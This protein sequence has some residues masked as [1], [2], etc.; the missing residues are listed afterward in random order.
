MHRANS[1]TCSVAYPLAEGARKLLYEFG[2]R[3]LFRG[4]DF[5]LSDWCDGLMFGFRDLQDPEGPADSED[6]GATV[7]VL[8]AAQ[9]TGNRS[10]CITIP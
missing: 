3:E 4:Y 1:T 5:M 8:Q 7:R 9:M 10:D 6:L 2:V